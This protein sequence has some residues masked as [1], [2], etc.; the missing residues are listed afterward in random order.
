MRRFAWFVPLLFMGAQSQCGLGSDPC[1]VVRDEATGVATI[2]CPDGSST[3][4]E[5]ALLGSPDAGAGCTV[6]RDGSAGTVTLSCADGTAATF[7]DG[8]AGPAGETGPAGPQGLKGDTGAQGL[9]WRG[10]WSTTA[11]YAYLDAVS[12]AGSSWVANLSSSGE[13]PG[14]V[15]SWQLL[16]GKGEAG[17]QGP[18]GLKGDSGAQ[19][20]QGIQGDK[21]DKGDTGAQG[22]AGAI[23]VLDANGTLVGS[24]VGASD[25]I[26]T[27]LTGTGHLAT[28]RWDGTFDPSPVVF[29]GAACAG[30]AF[31]SSRALEPR[32][33]F[34]KRV[35]FSRRTG[36]L[37]VPSG[38]S[39][40]LVTHGSQDN[41]GACQQASGSVHGWSLVVSTAADLGLPST[42]TGPL[43]LQ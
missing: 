42:L 7:R 29:S 4:V 15:S 6:T 18:T 10:A 22:P 25:D 38:T 17:S 39:S 1:T 11:S 26:V 28:L 8:A 31:L 2:T 12:H 23:R 37:Y 27:V 19:G 14:L 30:S 32:Q 21:G 40:S 13:E 43:A 24:A 33:L 35:V 9:T 34:A 5:P 20:A 16:A 3:V 36:L 41:L